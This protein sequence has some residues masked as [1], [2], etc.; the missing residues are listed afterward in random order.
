MSKAQTQPKYNRLKCICDNC[1]TE[2][3]VLQK[4]LDYMKKEKIIVSGFICPNCGTK[5]ITTVT[6][7]K[8]R[9]DMYQAKEIQRE[10][11]K[12]NRE[13]EREYTMYREKNISI[14]NKVKSKFMDRLSKK[15]N[16]YQEQIKKNKERGIQL[17]QWYI[18]NRKEQ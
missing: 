17:K 10:L 7:N 3:D 8:L 1:N 15:T 11:Y 6:D 2:I 4:E 14:P 13:M 16:E 5:F 12:I 9:A 18:N